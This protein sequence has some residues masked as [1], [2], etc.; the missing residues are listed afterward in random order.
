MYEKRLGAGRF[1]GPEELIDNVAKMIDSIEMVEPAFVQ[2]GKKL[3][4]KN[5]FPKKQVMALYAI[6][7]ICSIA[8]GE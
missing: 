6:N 4:R 2:E 3:F 1:I 5:P 8:N 7:K